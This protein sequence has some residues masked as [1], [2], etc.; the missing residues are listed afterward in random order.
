M[1]LGRQQPVSEVGFISF[2]GPIDFFPFGDFFL[3]EHGHRERYR[4]NQLFRTGL[5]ARHVEGRWF[6]GFASRQLVSSEWH[7]AREAKQNRDLFG[8]STPKHLL[9]SGISPLVQRGG[10]AQPGQQVDSGGWSTIR[11]IYIN[12]PKNIFTRTED[13]GFCFM[14]FFFLSRTTC[15]LVEWPENFGKRKWW[16]VEGSP[17]GRPS[18]INGRLEQRVELAEGKIYC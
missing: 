8:P 13:F 12:P 18:R 16:A 15:R 11:R 6:E 17:L 3:P 1:L 9:V 2:V 4:L 10:Q 5:L 7:S 14:F